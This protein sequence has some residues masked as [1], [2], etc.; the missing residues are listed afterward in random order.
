MPGLD[1]YGVLAALKSDPML[2]DIPVVFLTSRAGMEDVVAGLRGGAHDCLQNRSRAL[3]CWPAWD[4]RP[5]SRGCR[6]SSVSATPS[7]TGM[8]LPTCSP[9]CSTAATSTTRSNASSPTHGVTSTDLPADV[10]PRQFQTRERPYSHPSG[11]A[12]LRASA[13]RV[14]DGLR[15]GDTPGRWGGEEFLV[16]LPRTDSDGG[17]EVAERIRFATEAAPSW[18]AS[19]PLT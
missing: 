1:G 17:L 5:A 4:R 7:S 11:D 13:D 18:S 14:Q 19:P 3:N 16:I 15:M 8:S 9:G 2:K 12:V 10:R 6:T